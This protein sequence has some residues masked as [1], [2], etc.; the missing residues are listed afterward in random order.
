MLAYNGFVMSPRSLWHSEC[1]RSIFTCLPPM[2]E[3]YII[4]SKHRDT[5]FQSQQYDTPGHQNKT[6]SSPRS[7]TIAWTKFK[8]ALK[9][10][11]NL[12]KIYLLTIDTLD[13]PTHHFIE[14]EKENL[15]DL[16]IWATMQCRQCLCY[17]FACFNSYII[18]TTSFISFEAYPYH[19]D[20]QP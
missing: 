8:Y 4:V 6:I 9:T 15:I 18:T 16:C 3:Q 19:C 12:Y 20:N 11:M 2:T 1:R 13:E 14:I 5:S 7:Y 10:W 17:I